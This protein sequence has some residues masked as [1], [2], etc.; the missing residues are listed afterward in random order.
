MNRRAGPG[1]ER[2]AGSRDKKITAKT[3]A[4]NH[5]AAHI[6]ADP[7]REIAWKEKD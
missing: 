4:A 7:T 3:S 5:H 6:N 1:L 2:L